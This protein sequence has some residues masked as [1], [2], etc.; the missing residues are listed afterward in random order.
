VVNR[1]VKPF[2]LMAGV[3]ARQI[4]WMSALG[5]RVPLPLAGNGE[6]ICPNTG[7]RYV[8]TRASL[9]LA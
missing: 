7:R 4:G 9:S 6:W 3:P 8:L 5:E 2:A 1:N